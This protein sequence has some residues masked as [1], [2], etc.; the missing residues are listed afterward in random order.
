MVVFLADFL[1][2]KEPRLKKYT[3]MLSLLLD[4]AQTGEQ[5][6]NT[7]AIGICR[8]VIMHT[9]SSVMVGNTGLARIPGVRHGEMMDTSRSPQQTDCPDTL[10]HHSQPQVS[11][12]DSGTIASL[13]HEY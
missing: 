10:I 9:F 6:D 5:G 2:L 12:T 13:M 7:L 11:Q 8:N 1:M 3:T 4:M